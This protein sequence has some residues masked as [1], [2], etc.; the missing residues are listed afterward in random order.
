MHTTCAFPS[1]T[2]L[3]VQKPEKSKSPAKSKSRERGRACCRMVF[4]CTFCN[5]LPGKNG[6][7]AGAGKLKLTDDNLLQCKTLLKEEF[8]ENADVAEKLEVSKTA[9]LCF[10]C[11]PERLRIQVSHVVNRKRTIGT[12]HIVQP[13]PCGVC[14]NDIKPGMQ[15]R[16]LPCDHSFHEA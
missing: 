8:P 12:L 15:V 1:E 13:Q 11:F 9:T 7:R 3:R 5:G 10:E 16:T 14:R 2:V 6:R 4:V